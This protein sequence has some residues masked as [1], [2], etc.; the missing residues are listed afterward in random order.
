MKIIISLALLLISSCLAQQLTI[1]EKINS[2]KCPVERG[3]IKTTLPPDFD[4]KA[5]EILPISGLDS[6][7]KRTE[8][9]FK[10]HEHT[11][12]PKE[13]WTYE[14]TALLIGYKLEADQD[15]HIVLADPKDKTETMIVEIISPNCTKDPRL[16][17]M[18]GK[19]RSQFEDMYGV[20]TSRF[21]VL[22]PPPLVTV[23]GIFFFDFL[24]GQRGVAKNGVELHPV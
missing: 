22:K 9:E 12:F 16:K 3:A 18:S 6:I 20:P 11:R 23:T 1:P 4:S 10:A 14:V 8:E 13:Y 2:E 17:A 15:F 21:Y 7:R 24:H 5:P 19:L